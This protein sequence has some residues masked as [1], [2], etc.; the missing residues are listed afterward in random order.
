[1]DKLQFLVLI[2]VKATALLK[3]TLLRCELQ[4]C[5]NAEVASKMLVQ[6]LI[7]SLPF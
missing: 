3:I 2:D 1:M 6:P 4:K 5:E 7:T